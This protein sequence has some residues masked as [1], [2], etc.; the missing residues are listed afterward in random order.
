MFFLLGGER[1]GVDMIGCVNRGSQVLSN[2]ISI[3]SICLLVSV[4][5]AVGSFGEVL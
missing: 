4:L 1:G 5:L 2:A 3:A